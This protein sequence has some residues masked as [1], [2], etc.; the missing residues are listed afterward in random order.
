MCALLTVFWRRAVSCHCQCGASGP[1]SSWYHGL[2]KC[3]KG[4]STPQEWLDSFKVTTIEKPVKGK[5]GPKKSAGASSKAST[6]TKDGENADS[7]TACREESKVCARVRQI[8][9]LCAVFK[10]RRA[11]SLP[12]PALPAFCSA[13]CWRPGR[14]APSR[15]GV[16]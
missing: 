10:L 3:P 14:S 16:G 5:G 6:P 7:V 2:T 13:E 15:R 9:L 11:A 1:A 8:G 12:R 4:A